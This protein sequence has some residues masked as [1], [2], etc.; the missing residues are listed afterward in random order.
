MYNLLIKSHQMWSDNFEKEPA[1]V[2][3]ML[4][5]LEEHALITWG[6]VMVGAGVRALSMELIGYLQHSG[7]DARLRCSDSVFWVRLDQQAERVSGE[8]EVP[9]RQSGKSEPD[10]PGERER[11]QTGFISLFLIP[12]T[13]LTGS[14]AAVSARLHVWGQKKC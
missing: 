6:S 5:D 7:T 11:E 8:T 13:C 1:D 14:T 4:W 2:Q 10:L 9:Q 3:V 12:L